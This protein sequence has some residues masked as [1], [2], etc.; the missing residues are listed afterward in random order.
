MRKIYALMVL[1]F[2]VLQ[3]PAQVLVQG[4][5]HPTAKPQM[6]S[7][8]A[9]ADGTFT[10][11]M[12]EN[13]SGEG[14]NRAAFV[15]QWN[16]EGETSA[17]VW[18]FRWDGEATGET[19][20]RA[21]AASDPRFFIMTET[22]TAYGSTVSGF[23]Y[24]VNKSGDFSIT[25]DGVTLSPNENG[26]I[27]SSSYGYDGWT[28][29]DPEDYWQSGWY[30][31]YWSYWL[32]SSDSDAWGYS[33]T[34]I[35]GRK[36]T[37]GCWDGWNFAVNMSSQ[38]WK[39]LA[40]APKNGPTAPSVKVQPEDVTVSPGESVTFAPEF[41]GD[42]LY[43]QWYKDE[44]AIQDAEA[45]SYSIVSSETSDAGRYYCVVSNMLDTISTDTVTLVVGDKSVVTAPG[46]E[47]G[48]ALV[49]YDDS[50]ASFSGILT[51]PQTILIEGESYTVV[52][53]DDMA[54]MGCAKLTSV[55]FPSTL[56]TIGEGAFYGCSRLTSVELPAQTVSIG[57][58]VFGDCPLLATL[59]LGEGLESIGR[60]AF[61]NCIAL[62]GVSM[63]AGMESIGALAFKGCTK[64]AS[65]ALGN[66]LTLLGDSAFYGC[67]ALQSVELPVT[68]SSVGTRTFAG[69][70][71]LNAVGLGNVSAIGEA[72]FN[73]CS[74]LTEIAIPNGVETLG[75][76]AFYGCSALATVTLGTQERSSS[77]LKTIGDYAFA[78]TAVKSVVLPDGVSTLGNYAFNKCASLATVSLGNSLTAIGNYAFSDC[79]KLES[80]TF[81]S[82]LETIG[83]RAFASAKISSLV[84]P[85]TVKTIGVWAFYNNPLTAI[86]F[87][88]G[89]QS[90][91][92]R[93][94]YGVSV[95]TLN[96]PNSVTELGSYAFSGCKSL[97]TV[98][99]G[100]GVT[101][102]SDYTFNTCSALTQISCPSVTEIGKNA[103]SGCS[104]LSDIPLN[105]KITS[106]GNYV[107]S[108][109]S[110]IE[111]LVIPNS[112]TSIGSYA[113]EKCTKL[114]SAT[115]GTGIS[116]IPDYMF[117]SCSALTS[118]VLPENITGIG[119]YAFQSTAFTELPLT[120][121]IT[122]IK[123][124]AFK[125]CTKLTSVAIPDR[126]TKLGTYVFQ[127]CTGLESAKIGGGVTSVPNYMFHG[128]TNL[129]N[130]ELSEK[131]T[132]IGN[133]AFYNCKGLKS[134]PVTESI[135]SIGTNAFYGCTSL[136]SVNLSDKV[137]S[138]G[139]SAF[140]GCS[141][142]TE[143]VLGTGI[144]TLGS[145]LFRNDAKLKKVVANGK[146]A[147]V[148]TYTFNGCSSL[149]RIYI[150]NT[151]PT[152]ASSNTFTKVP[153]TCRIYVPAQTCQFYAQTTYWKD[154][155][156]MPWLD[157]LEIVS[158]TP[159]MSF[160]GEE[161]L[162]VKPDTKTFVIEFNRTVVNTDSVSAM[163]IRSG[164]PVEDQELTVSYSGNEVTVIREGED[165]PN[166]PYYYLVL[167]TSDKQFSILF[168]VTTATGI[169]DLAVEKEVRLREYYSVDGKLLPCPVEGI[170]IVKTV[171]EDGS[172]EVSKVYVK[173]EDCRR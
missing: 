26:I 2:A 153:T 170:N 135:T 89:L 50:Y 113:F 21:I 79:E 162:D 78:E 30:Q 57:N 17:L 111:S 172:I 51:I 6:V 129:V 48:T 97:E 168:K 99:I 65:A 66:S 156:I 45:S 86:T 42:S 75:N 67:S 71:A 157:E 46:E 15:V 155:V 82:A 159:S 138:L 53:I 122:E 109:C 94:F 110:A 31:G 5:P 73:G 91:G 4:R 68:V 37:D 76:Y 120:A 84:L 22:G 40:P 54:F 121:S 49:V 56:K 38:P 70:S 147:S 29:T 69:C 136:T 123:D 102:I 131:V 169:D 33:G 164:F 151:P 142:L 163:L 107:F 154:F 24:D 13:W 133:S 16:A 19:M 112:V 59:S 108:G 11:D 152:G 130:V 104:S 9:I 128:C 72:A 36:L 115:L 173:P 96:I 114:T 101:K 44:V 132:S 144:T 87:N 145:S 81:G 150:N 93:A 1:L 124:Y 88:D 64:L 60:S 146:I 171:Y 143:A 39:P 20:A 14:A 58:E 117:S 141:S 80:V 12:I 27:F 161:A 126:V 160:D 103:F 137:T 118:V 116:S 134:L 105:D 106:L 90:I 100:T 148:S 74:A 52:G 165:L 140:Y 83:E 7:P 35:T 119:K 47:P 77:S 28:C 166:G 10:M 25:K 43:F 125:S 32:K 158:T 61:E 98:T 3:L 62:T 95:Q 127:S 18:G 85:A 92:S 167:T 149:G 41:K 34:G 55:I 63:P 139:A 23:G 8:R